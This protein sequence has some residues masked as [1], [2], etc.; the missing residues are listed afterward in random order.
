MKFPKFLKREDEFDS[1]D[2]YNGNFNDLY[3]ERN[4]SSVNDDDMIVNDDNSA[5][6]QSAAG[7]AFGGGNA[8]V[9]LK[10]IKPTSYEDAPSI[11]SCLAAGT[12]VVLNIEDLNRE[13]TIR[14]VDFL[15]GAIHIIGGSM[16]NVTKTTLVFAPKNVGITGFESILGSE[17]N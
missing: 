4:D 2:L 7:V 1:E 13:N 17:E 11:A 8:P 9:S 15:M 14:L 5:D 3:G 12:T 10:V 6:A 16:E